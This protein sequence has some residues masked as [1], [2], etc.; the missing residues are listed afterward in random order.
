VLK[1]GLASPMIGAGREFHAEF[2]AGP[3]INFRRWLASSG[4]VAS[5]TPEF[6]SEWLGRK[7]GINN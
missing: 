2:R 4:L 3:E 1:V 7:H 5:G 6:H